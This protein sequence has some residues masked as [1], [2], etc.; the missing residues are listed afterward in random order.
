V[1]R[2]SRH[3]RDAAVVV[4]ATVLL[5]WYRLRFALPAPLGR[6]GLLHRRM[7]A[8]GRSPDAPGA[9]AP[10]L[11]ET[12]S[13]LER[14]FLRATRAGGS[15]GPR[16]LALARLFRLHGLAAELRVGMR[17]SPAGIAGHAW[18]VHHGT[19]IS[20]SSDFVASFVALEPAAASQTGRARP[21]A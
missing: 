16:S 8:W 7:R 12:A 2:S 10:G 18:V 20:Q 1:T 4:L 15:C 14:L 5:V 11:A 17:R 13:R 9:W 19:V 21:V 6:H 3:A